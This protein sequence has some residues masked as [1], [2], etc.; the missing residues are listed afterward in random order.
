[1]TPQEPDTVLGDPRI[2]D[3]LARISAP[4]GYQAFAETV[5]R[6]GCC[7]RPVRLK[8]RITKVGG[9]VPVVS[10]A[11]RDLPDG[12][13]LKACGSR[14]ETLCP[15]C[16]SVYRG[17]AFQLVAAGLRGGKGVAESVAEHPA[18]LVT[19][20]AP[21]FGAVHRRGHDGRCHPRKRRCPHGA[22]TCAKRHGEHDGIL[23]QALCP[24]CYDYEAAVLFNLTVSELWRRTSIY[25]LRA[26]AELASVSVREVGRLVRLSYVKVVEFQRRGSVHV[27]A[28][29]RLDGVEGPEQPVPPGFDAHMLGRAVAIAVGKVHAPVAGD[30]GPHARRVRWGRQLDVAPITEVANRR[31]RAA[32]YLAKY[33]TKTSDGRGLLDHRLRAGIPEHIGLPAQ[34]L[35]LVESAWTLGGHERYREHHLRAWAHTLGFRG[36]FATKSRRYSTTFGALRSARQA[37]RVARE[38]ALEAKADPDPEDELVE[39]RAWEFV[40]M[41]YATEGDAWLAEGL[42]DNARVARRAMY[43]DR[44]CE[45]RRVAS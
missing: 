3:I 19:L 4:G 13:L 25:V 27:H 28:V 8:G 1:M 14:R 18:V 34:L 21:S 23:G 17:D 39:V 43:E 32:A 38:D 7:R 22:M 35:R 41:G 26:V 5:K 29:I 20:T 11:T 2:D 40:G 9:A 37:W 15:P 30:R 36:H 6:A 10:F 45:W 12:V 16:A 42:A 33:S 31:A 24:A 44:A